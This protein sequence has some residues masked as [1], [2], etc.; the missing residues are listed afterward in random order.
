MQLPPHNPLGS[1]QSAPVPGQPRA[2]RPRVPS[3]QPSSACATSPPPDRL[4]LRWGSGVT[5]AAARRHPLRSPNKAARLLGGLPPDVLL[6]VVK[7]AAEPFS[8]WL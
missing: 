7:L 1:W 4:G 8:A 3:A 2:A 6:H 5:R